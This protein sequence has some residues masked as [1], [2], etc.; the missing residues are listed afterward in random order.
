MK[1]EF[2]KLSSFLIIIFFSDRVFAYQ[3]NSCS[4]CPIEYISSCALAPQIA[5]HV[6]IKFEFKNA[7]LKTKLYAIE[8]CGNPF[9]VTKERPFIDGT[10]E[11][12][13]I[14]V[15]CEKDRL[16]DSKKFPISTNYSLSCTVTKNIIC[17]E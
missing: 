3:M 7:D 10:N 17:E 13:L 8:E 2:I 4:C 12:E 11:G 6:Y 5:P 1:N 15:L 16:I 14:L 9:E